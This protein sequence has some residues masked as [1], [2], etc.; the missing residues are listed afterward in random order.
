LKWTLTGSWNV[1]S[2]NRDHAHASLVTKAVKRHQDEI[3]PVLK[4]MKFASD[5]FLRV[6]SE[7]SQVGLI[8]WK[9]LKQCDSFLNFYFRLK[10]FPLFSTYN[11]NGLSQL[12][13]FILQ[14]PFYN[15]CA[16]VSVSVFNTGIYLCCANILR[17]FVSCSPT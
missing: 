12:Y 1:C 17:T 15:D 5:V 7:D 13:L 10:K 4:I 16:F 8:R 14:I 2:V 9:G 3:Y 6:P 11:F